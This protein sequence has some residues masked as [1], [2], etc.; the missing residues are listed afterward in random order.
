MANVMSNFELVEQW[1]FKKVDA[2]PF[3]NKKI[4]EINW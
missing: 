3:L 1:V 4:D 2:S